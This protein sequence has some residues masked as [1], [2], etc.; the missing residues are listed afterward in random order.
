MKESVNYYVETKFTGKNI[1]DCTEALIAA[2][3]FTGGVKHALKF[4]SK[5]GAVPLDK[6]RLLETFPEIPS[7]IHTKDLGDFNVKI[8]ANFEDIFREY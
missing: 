7:T 3:M 4:V 5:I 1:A 8:D 6:S 2:Y